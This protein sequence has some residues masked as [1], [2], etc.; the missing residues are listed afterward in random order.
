[1][2]GISGLT[3]NLLASQEGLCFMELVFLKIFY[4]I[5]GHFTTR[6]VLENGHFNLNVACKDRD[7]ILYTT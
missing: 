1:M 2:R 3:K 5:F 7:F 6:I 4:T